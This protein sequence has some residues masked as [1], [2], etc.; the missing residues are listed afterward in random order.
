MHAQ[1][2]SPPNPAIA[3]CEL[4]EI[5]KGDENIVTVMTEAGEVHVDELKTKVDLVKFTERHKFVFDDSLDHSVDNDT[6]YHY[7]VQPLVQTIFKMGKATCFAYG[8]T[9]SG[10][11]YTMSPLPPRAAAE[12]LHLLRTRFGDLDL[13]VSCFEIYGN[14][15]CYSCTGFKACSLVCGSSIPDSVEHNV[16]E[17]K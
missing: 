10:K 1:G 11:T 12:I 9:G 13:F 7:T 6:V 4:Q 8:Q 5:E 3:P 14:K 15:V 16:H 17:A 2:T